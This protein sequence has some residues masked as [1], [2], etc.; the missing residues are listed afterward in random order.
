MYLH[1]LS[2]GLALGRVRN[3]LI[4]IDKKKE[5]EEQGAGIESSAPDISSV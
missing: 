5:E 1:H 3:R 2:K 4:E